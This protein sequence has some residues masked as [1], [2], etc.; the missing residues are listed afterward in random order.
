MATWLEA[1]SQI[2]SSLTPSYAALVNAVLDTDSLCLSTE[3]LTLAHSWSALL[4]NLVSAHAHYIT[5]VC[6]RLIQ[7]FRKG[8]TPADRAH[9][10]LKQVLHLIP[11]GPSFLAP[12]IS[13]AFPHKAMTVTEHYHYFDGILKMIGYAPVLRDHV[14]ALAVDKALQIDVEIQSGIDELEDEVTINDTVFEALFGPP[15]PCDGVTHRSLVGN[16]TVQSADMGNDDEDESESVNDDSDDEVVKPLVVS[17]RDTIQKLDAVL[18]LLFG[19]ISST[20]SA[21]TPASPNQVAS[22]PGSSGDNSNT[23]RSRSE[24]VLHQLF[25]SLLDIFERS[26]L[27][28]HRSRY[29]QFLW[30]HAC[31][32]DA[33]LP[34]AFLACLVQRTL[35]DASSP[36][37]RVSASAYIGSFL[38]RASYL[39]TALIKTCT[40]L[41]CEW[42]VKYVQQID[43]TA[44]FLP[45]ASNAVERGKH[46]VFYSVVQSIMYTFCFRWKELMCN[47]EGDVVYKNK[48]PPEL[49]GFENVLRNARLNPLKV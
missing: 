41:L 42:T 36:A 44:G 5:P 10:C 20:T 38:A 16:T 21:S 32:L 12:I 7:A 2:V 28:T 9:V 49:V 18:H 48:F 11:T 45:A 22:S 23:S 24:R 29:T 35:D 15:M 39:N 47:D 31:S 40:A 26:L 3:N 14:L 8:N 17:I 4:E 37:I 25:P 27:P 19:Y 1:L 33:T 13:K 43:H 34:D 30:F 6:E 46:L